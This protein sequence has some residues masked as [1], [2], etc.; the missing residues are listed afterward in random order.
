[1]ITVIIEIEA[2]A[3][4]G[5]KIIFFLNALLGANTPDHISK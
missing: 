5:R 2:L 4:M 3:L 1:M